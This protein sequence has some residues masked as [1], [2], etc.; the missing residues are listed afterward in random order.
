[1]P[2]ASKRNTRI[3]FARAKTAM[4]VA[5]HSRR[6]LIICTD[7]AGLYVQVHKGS[8]PVISRLRI[9]QFVSE[10]S[11]VWMVRKRR[12]LAVWIW[13]LD[14]QFEQFLAMGKNISL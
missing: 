11:I 7:V 4:R 13:F 1:M 14:A 5:I 2:Y 12:A 8:P 3:F 6:K 9:A 10:S